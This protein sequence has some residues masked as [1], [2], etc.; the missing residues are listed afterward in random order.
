MSDYEVLLRVTQHRQYPK[1]VDSDSLKFQRN[2]QLKNETD[3]D[4]ANIRS[5]YR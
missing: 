3:R 1:T 2:I 4:F 5:E